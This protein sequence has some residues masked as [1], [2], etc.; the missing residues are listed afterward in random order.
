VHDLVTG[1]KGRDLINQFKITLRIRSNLSFGAGF[2]PF[3]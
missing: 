1:V 2:G 3:I